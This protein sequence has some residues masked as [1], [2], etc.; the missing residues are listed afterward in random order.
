MEP[1]SSTGP[2]SIQLNWQI[3][4]YADLC[5]EGYRISGWMDGGSE[6]VAL[7][8]STQNNTVLFE[9]DLMAC[10]A[11]TIQIIPYTHENLDGELR[12][13]EVETQADVVNGDKV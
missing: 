11:Y 9:K 5:I 12:Q 2:F 7:S 1:H 4:S 10:Q 3:P 6:V 8:V 13:I